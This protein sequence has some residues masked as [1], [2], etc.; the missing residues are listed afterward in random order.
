MS[1]FHDQVRRT[2]RHRDKK[3]KSLRRKRRERAYVESKRVQYEPPEDVWINE[4]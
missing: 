2:Q 3:Y 1:K 4:R